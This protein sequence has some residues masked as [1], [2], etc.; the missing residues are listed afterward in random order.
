MSSNYF[1]DHKFTIWQTQVTPV[2]HPP[3][4]NRQVWG[5]HPV[6]GDV[7]RCVW[8]Q[9]MCC[10][11]MIWYMIFRSFDRDKPRI[12]RVSKYRDVKLISRGINKKFNAVCVRYITVHVGLSILTV[13]DT[14]NLST[15][16]VFPET[17]PTQ[18]LSISLWLLR[19]HEVSYGM[20]I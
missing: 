5:D 4:L 10:Y 9:H 17:T 18:N 12:N 7:C 2:V 11:C 3:D 1:N 20:F 14:K 19:S 8:Y 16:T 13:N 15:N 6:L